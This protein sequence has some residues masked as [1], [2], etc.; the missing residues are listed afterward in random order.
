MCQALVNILVSLS[1]ATVHAR[2][3]EKLEV[4]GLWW[5]DKN[6]TA[7]DLGKDRRV[8]LMILFCTDASLAANKLFSLIV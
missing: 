5:R 3:S 2:K 6:V 7:N 4:V 1:Q 8:E